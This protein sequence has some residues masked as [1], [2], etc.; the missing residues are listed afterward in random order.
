MEFDNKLPVWVDGT[1]P[2]TELSTKGFQAGYKPPAGVFNW[3]FNKVFNAVTELQEKLAETDT[4]K[5]VKSTDVTTTLLASDWNSNRYV[6]NNSNIV[7]ATQIIELAPAE[8]ITKEQL[9][10]LQYANIIGTAQAAGRITL[11]AYGEIPTMDIPVHFV[12]RGD[13]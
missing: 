7:S 3:F 4:N 9:E 8:N 11:T 10:A 12:I 6:W 2:S 13:V 1:E 5:S